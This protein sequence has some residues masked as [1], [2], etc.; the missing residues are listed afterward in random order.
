MLRVQGRY[1]Q[2]RVGEKTCEFKGTEGGIKEETEPEV[3]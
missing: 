1:R 3:P 2:Q